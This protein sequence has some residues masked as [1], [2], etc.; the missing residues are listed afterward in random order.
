M[1]DL[2]HYNTPKGKMITDPDRIKQIDGLAQILRESIEKN[3]AKSQSPKTKG[4]PTP[5]AR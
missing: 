4:Q 5:S 1:E 2:A 3:Q